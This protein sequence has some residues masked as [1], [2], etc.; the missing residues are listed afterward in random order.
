MPYSPPS[1]TALDF[2]LTTPYTPP[3]S[4]AINFELS[5]GG[6]PVDVAVTGVEAAAQLGTVAIRISVSI[7]AV[8]L[9]STTHLGT[10]TAFHK[11]FGYV[12]G[13]YATTQLG[14]VTLTGVGFPQT[15]EAPYQ[16]W[17]GTVSWIGVATFTNVDKFIDVTGVSATGAV[18]SAHAY[19]NII[20]APGVDTLRLGRYYAGINLQMIWDYG[21]DQFQLGTKTYAFDGSL[22]W[23]YG[24]EHSAIGAARLFN[25]TVRVDGLEHA[26][27]GTAF[28]SNFIRTYV[29]AGQDYTQVGTAFIDNN[30]RVVFPDGEDFA[31]VAYD[32][33]PPN[34][35][36]GRA[37]GVY[38]AEELAPVATGAFDFASIGTAW[39]SRDEQQVYTCGRLNT[40]EFGMATIYHA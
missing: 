29:Q 14:T 26:A 38:L 36:T 40:A 12:D 11:H 3:A 18:G 28:I 10:V 1:G 24:S 2:L 30:L 25:G 17:G 27:Y 21:R 33:S 39:I 35:I 37:P 7:A 22:S 15:I 23:V 4:T 6:T 5:P 19:G 31:V 34:P 16:N 8:G 32:F 13:V 9:S 20:N